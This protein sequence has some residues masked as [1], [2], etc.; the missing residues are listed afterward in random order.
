[1]NVTRALRF[2]GS[3]PIWFW[4]E[5]VLAAGYLIN[6]TS[7]TLLNG[8]T[9]YEIL[10]DTAPIYGH[11]KVISSLCYTH[12]QGRGGDKFASKSKKRIFVRYPHSKKG[13]KLYDLETHNFSCF[14]MLFFM[15]MSFL[16]LKKIEIWH[17]IVFPI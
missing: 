8:K 3:L 12:N 13:C 15:K 6:K 7:S 1:M 11:I 10:Y 17:Q 4:G 5:C 9:S 14:A 2:Q 16:L